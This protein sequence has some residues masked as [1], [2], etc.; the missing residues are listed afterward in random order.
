[1]EY[2]DAINS[3]D[4]KRLRSYHADTFRALLPGQPGLVD[5][6]GHQAFLL[7]N[8]TAFPDFAIKVT[9]NIA[10]GDYVFENWIASGTQSG[11]MATP[12][13]GNIPPTGHKATFHGSHTFEIKNGKVVLAKVYFDMASLVGQLEVM[14]AV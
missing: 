8:W 7:Q 1:M 5:E 11:P 4:Y 10:Q 14:P 9:R 3:H 13:G 2:V 6:A 12:T